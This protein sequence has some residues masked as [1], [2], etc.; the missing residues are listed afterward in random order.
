MGGKIFTPE[1]TT[2]IL[3]HIAHNMITRDDLVGFAT[4]Q[5]LERFAT[6]EDLN[7]IKMEMGTM[8]EDLNTMRADVNT[9]REDMKG[10]ATKEDMAKMK[11][12][13]LDHVDR[14]NH[15]YRGDIVLMIQNLGR[16]IDALIEILVEKRVISVRS[17]TMLGAIG[18]GL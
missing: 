10:F 16:K 11:Y 9:V 7:E 1:E 13:I 8:R 6:K 18:R 17:G 14:K 3:T 5:D 4:K 12:D 2:E 15:E